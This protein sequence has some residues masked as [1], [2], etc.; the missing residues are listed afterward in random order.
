[1]RKALLATFLIVA[2]TA[3]GCQRGERPVANAEIG[4]QGTP[5]VVKP[6]I[7]EKTGK[8]VTPAPEAY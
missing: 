1:M 3:G 4:G 8:K 5:D 7:D 6:Q 2:A